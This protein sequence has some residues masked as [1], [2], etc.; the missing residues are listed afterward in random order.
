MKLT[1][2]QYVLLI[3]IYLVGGVVAA[4]NKMIDGWMTGTFFLIVIIGIYIIWKHNKAV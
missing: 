3:G 4:L 1:F 2:W